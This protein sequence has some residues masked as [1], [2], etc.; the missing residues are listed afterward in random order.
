VLSR[1]LGLLP[2]TAEADALKQIVDLGVFAV[3]ADGGT[4]LVVEPETS[5]LLVAITTGSETGDGAKCST[6]GKLRVRTLWAETLQRRGPAFRGLTRRRFLL[7][8][9]TQAR[10]AGVR[11]S[12][13]AS[14]LSGSLRSASP[15]RL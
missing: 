5:N 9:S 8:A 13:G 7:P 6:A 1:Y 12:A 15:P 2:A 10:S 11:S 4:L 3:N 14:I